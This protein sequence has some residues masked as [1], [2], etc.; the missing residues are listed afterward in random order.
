MPLV[1]LIRGKRYQ[2]SNIVVQ[3]G[4]VIEVDARTRNRLVKSKHFIDVRDLEQEAFVPIPED[5]GTQPM[6]DSD[7]PRVAGA[8][9]VPQPAPVISGGTPLDQSNNPAYFGAEPAQTVDGK[10]VH[11]RSGSDIVN[12]R[13]EEAKQTQVPV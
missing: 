13:A 8:P 12:Q 9:I 11:T 10:T 7:A 1:K 6:V 5:A 2:F 4:E 3:N